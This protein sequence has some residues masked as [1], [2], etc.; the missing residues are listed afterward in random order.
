M[1]LF[2][3]NTAKADITIPF[4]VLLSVNDVQQGASRANA[5]ALSALIKKWRKRGRNRACQT[6]SGEGYAL[7]ELTREIKGS[8]K[9]ETFTGLAQPFFKESE[10][11]VCILR[12]WR[13]SNASYD[14][15]NPFIK[16][17]IDGFV[18]VGLLPDDSFHYLTDVFYHFESVDPELKPSD[19]M[20]AKRKNY[21]ARYPKRPMPPLPARFHFDFYR[22]SRFPNGN[23]IAEIAPLE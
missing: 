16:P 7:Q 13:P 19:E 1:N 3:Q 22:L 6:L 15:H 18:D 4:T 8:N 23:P 9:I 11:I 12:I 17:V 2:E 20:R 21:K 10:K 14:V 5:F